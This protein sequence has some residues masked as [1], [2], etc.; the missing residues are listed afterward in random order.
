[1]ELTGTLLISMPGMEDPRF[2]KSVILICAH[3]DQGAMGLIVNKPATEL[4][5]GDL[6]GQL[7]IAVSDNGRDI[8][9]YTGG[10]VERG[11]GLCCMRGLIK[12]PVA[13]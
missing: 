7:G 6:L 11:R 3:S 4:G 10:P 1:M 13:L 8:R 2:D 12:P 5:F 9:V